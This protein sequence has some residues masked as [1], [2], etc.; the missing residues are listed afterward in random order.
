MP[1]TEKERLLTILGGNAAD[2]PAVICPGGM[3][4][5]ATTDILR[6]AKGNFHTD[7]VI[8]AET[9]EEI[10]MATGFENL[11]VPFCMTVEAEP[12]GSLVD[13][14][15]AAV[16]P[17]VTAYG[18]QEPDEILARPLPDP[19]KEGRLPVVLEAIYILARKNTETPV[20]GNL[21]GPV[22][23]ATSVI[24]PM[25]FFR[26][27]RKNRKGVKLLLSYL[28]DYLIHFARLQVAAGA[29]VIAIADPTATGEILGGLNFR[30]FV[31]PC[32]ARLVREIRAAG[33]GAIVHI[34]GDAAVLLEELN[35]I[36]GNALSFDSLVNMKKAKEKLEDAPLMGNISTQ[37]LH[38]GTPE[39]ITRAVNNGIKSGVEIISPACGI[40]LQTPLWNLKTLTDTVKGARNINGRCQQGCDIL[41]VTKV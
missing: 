37:L 9:A 4:S 38:Q 19:Q 10:R 2:R 3:M 25:I 27:M 35:T 20:I 23:L 29:G 28:T 12:L 1:L 40:S 16:E 26:L 36:K 8:M 15:D 24:D 17:R 18:A 14:G 31:S 5:A 21:T 22:S 13:L 32:L 6:K 34:C 33:A 7:P 39:R 30:E 11:G 41:E